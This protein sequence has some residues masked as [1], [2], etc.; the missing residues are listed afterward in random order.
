MTNKKLTEV[1][2][3]KKIN[4]LIIEVVMKP[5]TGDKWQP[6]G[7]AELGFARYDG[8]KKCVV[9]TPASMANNM[10]AVCRSR[11]L[12]PDSLTD[13][14]RGMPMVLVKVKVPDGA[15]FSLT[16]SL[17]EGHRIGSEAILDSAMP[18]GKT[19][20][21]WFHEE[22]GSIK[23]K[24]GKKGKGKKGEPEEVVDV[25]FLPP[26]AEWNLFKVIAR[27]DPVSMVLGMFIAKDQTRIT[28]LLEA[29]MDATG[30][31]EVHEGGVHKDMLKLTNSGMVPFSKSEMTG[32]I[33]A[34]F[35]MNLSLLRSYGQGTKGLSE[36]DKSMVLGIALKMVK[37]LTSGPHQYR[38]RCDLQPFSMSITDENGNKVWDNIPEIDLPELFKEAGVG[39]SLTVEY[40]YPKW[41]KAQKQTKDTDAK[42]DE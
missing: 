5:V 19:F 4:R 28:R 38:T 34:T 36:A 13:D 42:T 18:D 41:A 14:F 23:A 11:G 17:N 8:G 6:A 27:N 15:E 26:D 35:K 24:K 22:V 30:V 25:D 7:F 10:E 39:P 1:L 3:S 9:D 12:G 16:D 40:P 20:R 21:D 37:G 33:K 29:T 2:N 32:A 31:E